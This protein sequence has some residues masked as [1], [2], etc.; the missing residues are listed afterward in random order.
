MSTLGAALFASVQF[1][2][3]AQGLIV[4]GVTLVLSTLIGVV[5]QTWWFGRSVRMNTVAVF[6]SLLFWGW[7][8][9]LP[10]LLLATPLTFGLKVLCQNIPHLQWISVVLEDHQREPGGI[11]RRRPRPAARC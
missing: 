1:H 7:L 11:L 3:L 4:A 9:G 6:V 10:G 5:L 8:W 2:S